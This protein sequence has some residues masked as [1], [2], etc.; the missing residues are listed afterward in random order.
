MKIDVS[1]LFQVLGLCPPPGRCQN[2]MGSY[3]CS[4]PPGYELD[5]NR[6][7]CVG[8][9]ISAQNDLSC[10][11]ILSIILYY[12]PCVTSSAFALLKSIWRLK[13]AKSYFRRGRVRG[14]KRHLR[15]WPMHQHRGWRD[16]RVSGWISI[17]RQA[18]LDDVHRCEGGRMLR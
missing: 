6:K 12:T 2:L 13:L 9:Y 5:H 7:K 10:D 16:L 11:F 8:P 1:A 3:I 4:C 17:E 14:D 15:E 18:E